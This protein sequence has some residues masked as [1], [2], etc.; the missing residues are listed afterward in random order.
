MQ[1]QMTRFSPSLLSQQKG[2]GRK[3]S[4]TSNSTVTA[5]DLFLLFLSERMITS[6]VNIQDLIL[7]ILAVVVLLILLGSL[8][9][10]LV[11]IF[12]YIFSSSDDG[13]N[14]AQKSLRFMIIGLILTAVLLLVFPLVFQKLNIPGYEV[15]TAS[16][17]FARV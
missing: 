10:L 2:T 11:A 7:T 8:Y 17:I 4:L 1:R 12:K 14:A 5:S 15:F 6:Y 16:S 13:R 3:R 9:A